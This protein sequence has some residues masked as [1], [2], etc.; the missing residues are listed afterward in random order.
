MILGRWVDE[1]M[2]NQFEGLLLAVEK[3]V[4]FRK[5][6]FGDVIKYVRHVRCIV[7]K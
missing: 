6:I 3:T 1:W 5:S 7:F 2:G 4:T